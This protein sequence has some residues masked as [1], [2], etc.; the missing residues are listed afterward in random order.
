MPGI[1]LVPPVGKKSEVGQ[2][3]PAMFT[4]DKHKGHSNNDSLICTKS[5]SLLVTVNQQGKGPKNCGSG[6]AGKDLVR[7]NTGTLTREKELPLM[8]EQGAI[9]TKRLTD[10]HQIRELAGHG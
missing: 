10:L 3:G 6:R 7:V 9:Y 5:G 4:P 2:H 1:A 8:A